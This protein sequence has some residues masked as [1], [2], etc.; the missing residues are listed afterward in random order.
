MDLRLDILRVKNQKAALSL[1]IEN[2]DNEMENILDSLSSLSGINLAMNDFT[3]KDIPLL[4]DEITQ[5]DNYEQDIPNSTENTYQSDLNKIDLEMSEKAVDQNR[6][7]WMPLLQLYSG[8]QITNSARPDYKFGIGLEFPL[9]DFG[10]RENQL[11]SSINNYKSWKSLY[12][13]NQRKLSLYLRQL[14]ENSEK[15]YA[16]YKNSLENLDNAKK[17]MSAANILY[18]KGK[19]TETDLLSVSLD[20]SN[21]KKQYYESLYNYL[22]NKSEMAYFF[23]PENRK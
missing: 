11:Q 21:A 19:I 20:W 5:L 1:S 13:D 2:A 16:L 3:F 23:K 18:Q 9:F 14:V 15:S 22:S 17:S 12:K 4:K 8:L 7:Y 10:Q 6:L